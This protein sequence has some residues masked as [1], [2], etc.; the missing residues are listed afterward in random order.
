MRSASP[1]E[2][3]KATDCSK[4]CRSSRAELSLSS[5]HVG[6]EFDRSQRMGKRPPAP[7][8]QLADG[9]PRCL[10]GPRSTPEASES[11]GLKRKSPGRE[12]QIGT[13]SGCAFRSPKSVPSKGDTLKWLLLHLLTSA[14]RLKFGSSPSNLPPRVGDLSKLI[15]FSCEPG[16]RTPHP[17]LDEPKL[18]DRS[19]GLDRWFGTSRRFCYFTPRASNPQPIQNTNSGVGPLFF[20]LNFIGPSSSFLLDSSTSLPL[21]PGVV[22]KKKT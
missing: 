13:T 14:H 18:A 1:T 16:T 21:N 9:P 7:Q 15:E 2:R 10:S 17:H 20:P 19:P 8:D 6:K 11:D 12:C 4:R 5:R 22:F 3:R